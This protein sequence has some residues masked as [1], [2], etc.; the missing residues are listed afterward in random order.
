MNNLRQRIEKLEMLLSRI[1]EQIEVESC[2]CGKVIEYHTSDELELILAERCPAHGVVKPKFITWRANNWPLAP[3]HRKYCKCPPNLWREFLEGKRPRPTT[4]ELMDQHNARTAA[5][6]DDE[7]EFKEEHARID[8]IIAR[9]EE[10]LRVSRES[11]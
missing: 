5:G 2:I 3:E 10:A 1:W 9:H 8:C 11:E 7:R 4:D 6:G